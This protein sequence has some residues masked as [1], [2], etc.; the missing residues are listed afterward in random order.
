M[1]WQE[2]KTKVDFLDLFTWQQNI[3]KNNLKLTK[4]FTL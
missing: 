3:R 4:T 1:Q 2:Y